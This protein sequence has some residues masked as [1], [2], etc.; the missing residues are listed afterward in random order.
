MTDTIRLICST[1]QRTVDT[2]RVDTDPPTAVELRGI[3][4]PECD[5]GGFDMP[6][7]VDGNGNFVSGEFE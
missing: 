5:R 3:V 1:C 4:C 7:Y 6:E 2:P